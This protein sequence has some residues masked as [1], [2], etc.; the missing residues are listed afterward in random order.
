MNAL[1]RL[2]LESDTREALNELDSRIL[3]SS[4]EEIREGFYTAAQMAL[5]P[6]F[7]NPHLPKMYNILREL[8]PYLGMED[9][10]ALLRLE[11]SEYAQRTKLPP[12]PRSHE[13]AKYSDAE[14]EEAIE[15]K[16]GAKAAA[17]LSALQLSG[18]NAALSERLLRLG[19]GYLDHSLGHSVSCTS[20]IL[21]EIARHSATDSWPSIS[22]L[23]DYYCKGGYASH[24][25][26]VLDASSTDV[27]ANIL[28][29][30]SGTGIGSLHDAITIYSIERARSLV[31]E[32]TVNHLI[33]SWVEYLGGKEDA[34]YKADA[35]HEAP[36]YQKMRE[37]IRDRRIDDTVAVSLAL[38]GGRDGVKT[39]GAY[40]LKSLCE[41]Y[42]GKYDPHYFTG[43]GSL[44]WVL[45]RFAVR[46][47]VQATA[48]YQYI[49][50]VS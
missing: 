9:Q 13:V 43:L 37:L 17:A 15:E 12:I 41:G 23:A 20:F 22:V 6:P 34:P 14:L 46:R 33:G 7:I 38:L 39:L 11:V 42:K 25:E 40:L 24:E 27:D 8:Y 5:N 28:R 47:D 4:V 31:G 16:D 3:T 48:L 1:A 30:V 35:I 18:G 26:N 45:D 32:E 50:F 19:G 2:I 49:D 36:S 44:L 10:K 29:A 21:R